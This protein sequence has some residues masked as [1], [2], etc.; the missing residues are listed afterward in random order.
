MIRSSASSAPAVHFSEPTVDVVQPVLIAASIEPSQ[1]PSSAAALAPR[2]APGRWRALAAQ[3]PAGTGP[4]PQIHFSSAA[5]DL[6]QAVV[7]VVTAAALATPTAPTEAAVPDSELAN[8]VTQLRARGVA[9]EEIRDFLQQIGTPYAFTTAA[10]Q[11]VTVTLPVGRLLTP[12]QSDLLLAAIAAQMVAVAPATAPA[13][14][15]LLRMLPALADRFNVTIGI[16]PAA[17]GAA[18]VGASLGAGILFAP[19]GRVGVYGSLGSVVGAIVS[20][21]ATMQVTIV[22][23]GPEV[24]GGMARAVTID[25]GAGLVGSASALLSHG[26]CIGVT[27]QMRVDAGPTPIE[28]YAQFQYPP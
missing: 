28:T 17:T 22:H 10:A 13:V 1:A 2:R 23:G 20:I 6:T 19:G 3:P 18:T 24:F 15:P 8:T 9:D 4:T 26:R 27:F 12:T 21:S 16:G 5:P 25:G 7:P 11:Q 14:L